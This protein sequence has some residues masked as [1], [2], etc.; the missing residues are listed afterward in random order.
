MDTLQG[1]RSVLVLLSACAVSAHAKDK[2]LLVLSDGMRWDLFGEDLPTFNY[3]AEMGVK[4]EYLIP[5][6]PTMSL[7]NMYTIA[8]GLYAESHGAI[9][10][11]AFDPVSGNRT[12]TY[13]ASLKVQ[14]WFDTGAE[15]IWVTAIKQGLTAGT[16]RYP[17]GDVAIK[18][19]RP[20]LVN[21]S[22]EYSFTNKMD[23]AISW[24]KD[25]DL[26]IVMTYFGEPDDKLHK[27]GV[28]SRPAI[29]SLELMDDLLRHMIERLK[30]ENM[31]DTVNVIVTADHGFLNY[32]YKNF[33]ELNSYISRDDTDFMMANYGPTFQILPKEDKMD[34]VYS[35]LKNA[36]PH[37]HVHW[38][39]DLP[40]YFHYSNNDRILPIVGYVDPTWHVHTQWLGF[41]SVVGDHGFD[42]REQ[43]MRPIFYAMGPKFRKNYNSPPIFGVDIYPMMCE[44]LNLHPAPNNG[45]RERYG[46]LMASSGTGGNGVSTLNL[47]ACL[48][49]VVH[50]IYN[51]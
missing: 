41:N 27:F 22:E 3:I 44:I 37:M 31:M 50:V 32:V 7:P 11:L 35:S 14:E 36:H 48:V 30:E 21:S 9:H 39:K 23:T 8:T 19:I 6:F 2:I 12:L 1:I 25:E 16:M 49:A 47:I 10:N 34:Q 28:G 45:S 42:N 20:T 15:P 17:G 5:V 33:I 51:A 29:N 26:D 13:S 46:G 43:S 38:K 18:G 4:A 24:L 40:E